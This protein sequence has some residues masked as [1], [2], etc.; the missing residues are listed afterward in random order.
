MNDKPEI[1]A[2]M[3]RYILEQVNNGNYVEIDVNE[4]R[5]NNHQL[6][7]V[8]YNFVVSATSSSTK[9]RMTAD[10]SMPTKSG[11]SLNGFTQQAPE[12]VLSLRGILFAPE[13][14]LST[15][16]MASRSSSGLCAPVTRTP[17][18]GLFV[19][20]PTPSPLLLLLSLPGSST[21]N[22][23]C[24]LETVPPEII[25]PVPRSL[26]SR[27]SSMN[28][29]STYSLSFSKQYWRT[30][31]SMMEVLELVLAVKVQFSRTKS[32]RFSRRLGSA[33]NPGNAPVRTESVST[34]V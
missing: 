33:S 34:W 2:E 28:L 27:H 20:P 4:A 11:L 16:S 10:S 8:G 25:L 22:E 5:E 15:Q 30:P 31:I 17:I 12:D 21:E 29:L 18:S 7:F 6:Q 23:P 14:T 19:F 1:A 32:T 13:T 3:D 24:P 26:Q 9:V